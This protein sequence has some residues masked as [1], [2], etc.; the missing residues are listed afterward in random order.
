LGEVQLINYSEL[1]IP[2]AGCSSIQPISSSILPHAGGPKPSASTLHAH[3]HKHQLIAMA[4]SLQ[5][6]AKRPQSRAKAPQ[7]RAKAKQS[8]AKASQPRTKAKQAPQSRKT[9]PSDAKRLKNVGA[10]IF[11]T[12]VERRKVKGWKKLVKFL[13][14]DYATMCSGFQQ[15]CW[16]PGRSSVQLLQINWCSARMHGVEAEV[17][18]YIG[19]E[20][21]VHLPTAVAATVPGVYLAKTTWSTPPTGPPTPMASIT[22]LRWIGFTR[23]FLEVLTFLELDGRLL[24]DDCGLDKTKYDRLVHMLT[25][26]CD[27]PDGGILALLPRMS[28]CIQASARRRRST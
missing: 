13:R 3:I 21:I 20:G 8:R 15:R 10:Q 28:A 27:L 14:T 23:E 7:S 19:L 22:N 5:S 16:S 24:G 26:N 17:N 6:Q 25:F 12:M 9:A 11:D 1:H 2:C 18:W 4:K